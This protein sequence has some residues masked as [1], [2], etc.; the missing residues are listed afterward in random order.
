MLRQRPHLILFVCAV[1]AV[2]ARAAQEGFGPSRASGSNDASAQPSG[3]P[4]LHDLEAAKGTAKQT[5]RLVLVHFWTPTCQPCM[6]LEQNV[7]NQFGVAGALEA[8][9]VPVKLNANDHAAVAQ[10]YGITR[11]PTDVVITPEG[12]VVGKLISP[13]TPGAYV[14]DLSQVARQHVTR[15]GHFAQVSELAPVAPKLNAAYAHLHVA[16]NVAPAAPLHTQV[17]PPGQIGAAGTV[18][19]SSLPIANT[20]VAPTTATPVTNPFVS[21]QSPSGAVAAASPSAPGPAITNDRYAQ[22][23]AAAAMPLMSPPPAQVANP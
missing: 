22:A 2:P 3:I 7:F 11:V 15:T 16:P 12:Q 17:M 18:I 10:A 4:W 5:G 14:A 13:P 23:G 19:G 6:A 9:F 8:Q 21:P 1:L 20:A